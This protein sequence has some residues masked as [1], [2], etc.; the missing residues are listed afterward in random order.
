MNIKTL[1]KG[2]EGLGDLVRAFGG[3]FIL[4]VIFAVVIGV[5]VYQTGTN[6]TLTVSNAT[7]T[8]IDGLETA[9]DTNVTDNATAASGTMTGLIILVVILALFSVFISRRKSGN[10]GQLG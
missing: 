3:V 9:Y 10:G 5:L 7:Q 2:A 1:T 4:L 8:N 6:G